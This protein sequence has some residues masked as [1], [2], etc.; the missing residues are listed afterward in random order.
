MTKLKQF[1]VAQLAKM[2]H[3]TVSG[4]ETKVICGAAPYELA[5]PNDIT[6]ASNKKY[7]KSIDKCQASVLIVPK[8]CPDIPRVLIRVENPQLAFAK[9]LK[10]FYAPPKPIALIDEKAIV[11]QNVTYGED[12][13]ISPGAVV[14]D[15]VQIGDRV[16][17]RPGVVIG[18]HVKIGSDVH[19]YP[20]VSILD[21]CIIGNNVIIHAGTVIGSDGYGFVSD[22][23]VHHK[24]LHQGIVQIDDHVEIGANNCIDRATFGKTHI[25]EGVKTDNLVHVAHNVTI[26]E[27]S[28]IVG[29][30]GIAGSTKIGNRVILAGQSGVSGHLT[31][32]D[33]AVVGPQA[34]VTRSVGPGETVSGTPEMPHRLWLRV[35]NIVR[36]LPELRKKIFDLEK[37][38]SKL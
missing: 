26:G 21:Q 13:S 17:L 23:K 14:G 4:D 9:V 28:I 35:Q 18:N 2:I 11:G 24:I 25:K 36:N 37:R 7:L 32:G 22:G 27:H 33:R 12:V 5:T 15:N 38:I 34:G 6:Y 29:Q 16:V 1:S 3:G 20:N 10:V 30:V 31:I 8:A 19:I